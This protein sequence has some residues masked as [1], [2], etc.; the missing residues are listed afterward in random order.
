MKA[1]KLNDDLGKSLLLGND[2]RINKGGKVLTRVEARLFKYN[3]LITD[4]R[5]MSLRAKAI[6]LNNFSGAWLFTQVERVANE[7]CAD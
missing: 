6:R 5:N 3:I 2:Y 7:R 4:D 1:V